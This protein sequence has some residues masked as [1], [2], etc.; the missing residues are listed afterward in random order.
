LSG[1]A[2]PHPGRLR[3]R[4]RWPEEEAV[5]AV[6]AAVQTELDDAARQ[7][8]DVGL[9]VGV[10]RMI[11]RS[12]PP[13]IQ[14]DGQH[15]LRRAARAAPNRQEAHGGTAV[16]RFQLAHWTE[17]VVAVGSSHQARG[18]GI[19]A[20]GALRQQIGSRSAAIAASSS[21][22]RAVRSCPPTNRL[23]AKEGHH[24]GRRLLRTIVRTR[25]HPLARNCRQASASRLGGDCRRAC[26]RERRR[27]EHP[28]RQGGGAELEARPRR[29]R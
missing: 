10:A 8:A 16:A 9:E 17:S 29:S 20:G 6:E 3:I 21:R 25:A 7:V 13:P 1:T 24:L 15:S 2:V 4:R 11:S 18:G 23:A 14:P 28:S 5:E 19:A 12:S 22:A 27:R 26:A